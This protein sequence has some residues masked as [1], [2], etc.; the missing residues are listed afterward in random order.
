L[1]RYHARIV[2]ETGRSLPLNEVYDEPPTSDKNKSGML[3]D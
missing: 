3:P 2:T 1:K